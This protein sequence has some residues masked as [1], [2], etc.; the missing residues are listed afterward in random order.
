[1]QWGPAP[2]FLRFV[3]PAR[4]RAGR[5]CQMAGEIETIPWRWRNLHIVRDD[6]AFR[7]MCRSCL[8]VSAT[9]RLQRPSVAVRVH[10]GAL[11][12]ALGT[13]L[14]ERRGIVGNRR[15]HV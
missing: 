3:L 5:Y 7:D 13:A 15:N 11:G 12:E 2:E 8:R 1:M 14:A 10:A 9:A 6:Q 4:V